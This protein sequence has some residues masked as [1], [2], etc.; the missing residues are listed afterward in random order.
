MKEFLFYLFKVMCY[1][2]VWYFIVSIYENSFDFIKWRSLS[3][4][5]YT[6]ICFLILIFT[7]ND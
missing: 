6:L 3:T 5:I 4:N 7:S 1:F 2:G